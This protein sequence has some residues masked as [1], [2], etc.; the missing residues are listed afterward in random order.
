MLERHG[1]LKASEDAERKNKQLMAMVE[2]SVKNRKA[3][4]K[5]LNP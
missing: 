4:K 3:L 5:F 2:Q 1:L